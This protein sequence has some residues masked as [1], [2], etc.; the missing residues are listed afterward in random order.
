MSY[1]RN[2]LFILESLYFNK[3]WRYFNKNKIVVLMYHGIVPDDYPVDAWTLVKESQFKKQ[4]AYLKKYY[5]VISIQEAFRSTKNY[6]NDLKP[7][8]I[9]TFDDG[10]SNNYTVAYPIL[11][12]FNFPAI[13]FLTTGFIDSPEF[14]W[15]DKII[16]SIQR[17]KRRTM[18][19]Q[20]NNLGIH[21]FI[22]DDKAKRWDQIDRLLSKLKEEEPTK[23]EKIASEIIE[24]LAPDLEK[25]EMLRLLNGHE[26]SEMLA[27]GLIEFGSHTHYHEILTQL[28]P[29]E[30]RK[31]IE[32]S[33]DAVFNLTGRKVRYFAY[34][35]G[36]FNK[37][38]VR[39]LQKL[40]IEAAF[41]T[42]KRFWDSVCNIYEIPRLA[43]G[44]YDNIEIYAGFLSGILK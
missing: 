3:I 12:H 4:M 19:L 1:K 29:K 15:F 41:T 38:V 23:R 9:I 8:A 21:N 26:I 18:D 6:K 24:S 30:I 44:G 40:E 27:Q 22:S 35:N 20:Q 7:R 16:Y 17:T 32:S 37:A 28:M 10:Y 5:E 31:T 36:N 25:I 33:I 34:P 2:V 14:F 13:I 39:E 43:V 42:I 11:K